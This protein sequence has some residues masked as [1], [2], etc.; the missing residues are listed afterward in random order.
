MGRADRAGACK[1]ALGQDAVDGPSWEPRP[2]GTSEAEQRLKRG[3]LQ[4]IVATASLELGI[5]VGAVEL[6][7]QIDSPKSIAAAIQRI[8]RVGPSPGAIAKGRFFAMTAGRPARMCRGGARDS[9]RAPGRGRDARRMSGR[10]GAANRRDCGEEEEMSAG[11]N[12]SA[13][14]AVRTISRRLGGAVQRLLER[15]RPRYPSGSRALPQDFSRP[16]R[17]A[18]CDRGA[19][20]GWPRS[21]RAGPYRRAGNYDVVIESQSRKIGDVEEDFAQE[22]SRTT[23]SRWARCRGRSSVSRRAG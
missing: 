21:P 15:W 7:C 23:S 22:A 20:R 11:P 3:E 1:S 13:S 12:C 19:A 6:V 4:A 2:R 5:D 8:G 16:G 18:A 17:R 10:R 9:R 14:C